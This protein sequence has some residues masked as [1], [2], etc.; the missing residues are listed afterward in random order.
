MAFYARPSEVEVLL[1][2][3]CNQQ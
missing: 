1:V 2:L 3:L